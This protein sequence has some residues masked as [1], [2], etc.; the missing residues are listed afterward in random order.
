MIFLFFL[1]A[2]LTLATALIVFFFQKRL[3]Q[4]SEELKD[5]K[6]MRE[7][8]EAE[9][10]NNIGEKW[11]KES[12]I[13]LYHH[14]ITR[15][16][17]IEERLEQL[18]YKYMKTNPEVH[19]DLQSELSNLKSEFISMLPDLIHDDLFYAFINIPQHIP[20]TIVEKTILFL[21]YSNIPTKQV[22]TILAINSGN[23]RVKRLNLRRKLQN[24]ASEIE[25]L[26]ELLAII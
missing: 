17:L 11:Q 1:L 8:L 24:Y 20:L 12:L 26:N 21:L 19:Q 25:N 7:A 5:E 13:A 6:W 16:R 14:I 9:A 23:L 4:C 15:Y 3:N 2:L 10:V 18:S 22:A